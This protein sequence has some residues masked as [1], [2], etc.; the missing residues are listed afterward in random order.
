MPLPLSLDQT[1]NGVVR[2]EW[3]RI[4]AAL[5]KAIGD[6]QLAE[7]CLQ[8]AVARAIKRWPEA[9]IPD[10]PA[11]WLIRT[12]RNIAIDRFRRD[13]RH[14]RALPELTLLA[15][16]VAEDD[17]IDEAI[18]DKRL[19]M[20]FTCCHPALEEK[21]RV[22]LT[23]R[24]LGGLTT[25]E[26]AASFLDAP[27]T[28]AQRLVRA[29]RKIRA[30]GIPYRIPETSDLPERMQAVLSVIYLIFSRGNTA[31]AAQSQHLSAEA[32]RLGRI[33]CQLLPDD[34]E[35]AGLLAL[36]LLT[37]ARKAGRL[38]RDGHFLPLEQQN[39][40]RWDKARIAEGDSI[41]RKALGRG[42]VGP[43]QLQAAISACHATSPSWQDTNWTEIAAL[44]GL[45]IQMVP[46]PVVRLN[47]AVALSYAGQL[48]QGYA[49]LNGL[50]GNA[51]L[52]EY[53]PFHAARADL[54]ARSGDVSAAKKHYAKAIALSVSPTEQLFL[55]AKSDSLSG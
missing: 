39:R 4:L 52:R 13:A 19:E 11:A 34:A 29:K 8:E 16:T 47:H 2:E 55:S 49:I 31:T 35:V 41:L 45:L 7:D 36:M 37:D 51:T 33:L 15:E 32:I 21:T 6:L 1:I 24:T 42:A 48:E 14:D 20:I 28:M 26:I 9:G 38:D 46:T 18:P 43:Y 12:A 10:S 3:G 22:A 50:Q 17:P 5:T 27:A 25:E 53:Q 40:R 54:A 44:Y 23:L 30:A